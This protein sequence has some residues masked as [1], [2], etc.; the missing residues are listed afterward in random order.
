MLLLRLLLQQHL[1]CTIF[2]VLMYI[3]M[4]TQIVVKNPAWNGAKIPA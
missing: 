2:L 1:G 3:D 4:S